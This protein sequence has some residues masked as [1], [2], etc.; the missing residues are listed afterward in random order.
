MK[1]SQLL[2][3]KRLIIC[4]GSGGV[5]KT[6]TA[7]AI[8]VQAALQ[9]KRAVVLTIDPARRLANSLG[10][11]ELD[12]EAKQIP[13]KSF[14]SFDLNPKG[15]LFALMLDTKRTFDKIIE[16]YS[17]SEESKQNILNNS[18]YQH[19]SGMIAGSQEYM[20]MEK[21][22]ELFQNENY[23][24]LVLDTPP[25]QHALDFLD[26]PQKMIHAVSD[27]M[28]K[29]FL[30]PS[31]F[32][33]R[34]SLK[35]LEKGMRRVLKVFDNVTGY[36][37]LQDLSAMLISTAGLLEGFRDR[38]E[39]VSTLLKNDQTVFLLVTAP[40]NM[41][42]SEALYFHEKILEY[43]LPFGGFI[44]NRV[45]QDQGLQG[46]WTA[47]QEALKTSDLSD[48]QREG[49]SSILNSY[50]NLVDQDRKQLKILEERV[51]KKELLT[52]VPH[53]DSDVHDLGGLSELGR[54]L[55]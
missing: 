22:Y 42:L 23:D 2:D 13:Q 38:A 17:P 39:E 12:H 37:F 9:G 24:L 36:E 41:V 10:L 34:T 54:Y 44:V 18:L 31:L 52:L 1:L 30:K 46:K 47:L 14:E 51:K 4:C 11:S 53:L 25:T 43:Q 40:Q 55:E 48:K 15:K 26:A 29:W 3:S 19:L 45:H 50:R 28:L 6:T 5:G 16:R 33:G 8:A 20:A 35:F 21:V 49:L 7:A 27:S 32:V